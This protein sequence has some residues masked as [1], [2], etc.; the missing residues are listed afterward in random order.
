MEY[1]NAFSSTMANAM[2]VIFWAF[3]FLSAIK[4]LPKLLELCKYTSFQYPCKYLPGYSSISNLV[5][6]PG[7]NKDNFITLQ[8][9]LT[10]FQEHI[11][12][13]FTILGV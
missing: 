13:I 10:V 1:I 7:Y 6:G 4:K 12:A 9:V 8:T 2:K 3:L 5:L 11:F